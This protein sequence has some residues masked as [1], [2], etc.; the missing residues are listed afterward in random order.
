MLS[1][2]SF[3][4]LGPFLAVAAIV[5]VLAV[6]GCVLVWV[7]GWRELARHYRTQVPPEGARNW[8]QAMLR[9]R[10]TL[11]VIASA[12]DKGLHLRLMP[13]YRFAAAPLF[14]PWNEI[15]VFDDQFML[16]DVTRLAFRHAPGVPLL[17][18]PRVASALLA[19]G[20]GARRG[21][22]QLS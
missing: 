11:P 18:E 19:A 20:P 3:D 21:V 7:A 2:M 4:V 10:A 22:L 8:T 17:L 5:T 1:R 6:H 9:K 13:P 16:R 15:T 12:D 14:I